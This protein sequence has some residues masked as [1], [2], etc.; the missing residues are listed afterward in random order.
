MKPYVERA[1]R[2]SAIPLVVS[3]PHTGTV[4]PP[5]IA[6]ELASDAM[7]AQPM[8]D[9]H[10]AE[11]Y[12]FLPELGA[13]TIHA[14]Y[15]RF[16]VDLNRSPE[17]RAL[18][19]GRFETGLVPE[20]TFQGELIYARPPDAAT[21]EARKRAYHAPYH[22]QL[23]RL[24]EDARARFGGVVLVD[25]HSVASKANLLHD[26]LTDDIFL[27]NRDGATCGPWLMDHLDRSFAAQG[28]RV[29][30]N[31]PYKGGYITDHYG[32]LPG[33]EAVQIEMCQRVYMREDAPQ[34]APSQPAFRRARELLREVFAELGDAIRERFR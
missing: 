2:A 27:G 1:P 11:L 34:D 26:E 30:R 25:A 24:L 9:W 29:S 5:E 16:V 28:L 7:R 22:A 32:R 19:P 17:P 12:D 3:I 4:L 21:I 31:Q 20:K 8:T 33:V 10:L 15:S 14:V 18:Y 23:G 13:T 6:A